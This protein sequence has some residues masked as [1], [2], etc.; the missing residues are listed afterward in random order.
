[1]FLDRNGDVKSLMLSGYARAV[2]T[3]ALCLCCVLSYFTNADN[4][5]ISYPVMSKL[6]LFTAIG[7]SPGGS[8]IRTDD[9][10]NFH[11]HTE[12]TSRRETSILETVL[13]YSKEN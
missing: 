7:F 6:L 9:T 10:V 8:S 12:L 13:A 11:L 1:V 3:P 4:V 5:I 2:C